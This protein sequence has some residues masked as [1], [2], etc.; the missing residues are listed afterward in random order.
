M[1]VVKCLNDKANIQFNSSSRATVRLVKGRL[2][3][4]YD[5]L[6]YKK[7]IDT[8]VKEWLNDPQ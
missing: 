4:G 1:S 6:D 5:W 8:K 2:C 7:V 3:E